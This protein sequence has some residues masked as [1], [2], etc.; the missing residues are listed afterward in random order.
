MGQQKLKVSITCL[1]R[2]KTRRF[3]HSKEVDYYLS[4]SS[5][6]LASKS[7]NI[8]LHKGD[9]NSRTLPWTMK[10]GYS[11]RNTVSVTS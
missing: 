8:V 11:V 7:G 9:G 2:G 4:D 1:Y 3:F 10:I 6:L 5:G